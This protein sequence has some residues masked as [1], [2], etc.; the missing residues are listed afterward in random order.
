MHA[1]GAYLHVPDLDLYY[2]FV[3][4][5]KNKVVDKYDHYITDRHGRKFHFWSKQ[6]GLIN[7]NTGKPVFEYNLH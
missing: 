3:N 7:P 1:F 5:Y 4:Y 6:G 2:A